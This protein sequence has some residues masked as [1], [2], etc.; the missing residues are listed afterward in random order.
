[1]E[2]DRLVSLTASQAAIDDVRGAAESIFEELDRIARSPRVLILRHD[3]PTA[4]SPEPLDRLLEQFCE[5]FAGQWP[6]L[7]LACGGAEGP[8]S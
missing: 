6:S 2:V 8:I 5:M 7:T 4:P 1:M 3:R